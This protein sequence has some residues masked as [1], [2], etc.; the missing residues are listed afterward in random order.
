MD[1]KEMLEKLKALQ[2][3]LE[4]L[5]RYGDCY[6]N[7]CAEI[8]AEKVS[9]IH[10][11]LGSLPGIPSV[12][13]AM[14]VFPEGEAE[15]NTALAETAK[16]KS[17]ST[18]A[19]AAT[20]GLAILMFCVPKPLP[21]FLTG[22]AGVVWYFVY[23]THKLNKQ[24]LA[25]KEKAYQESLERHRASMEQFHLA[26]AAYPKEVKEGIE[27]A[28]SFGQRYREKQSE[29][30]T[31]LEDYEALKEAA[32]NRCTELITQIKGHDYIPEEYFHHVPKLITLL[33][34]GRADS[35]KEALN[36]AID[37]ERQDAIEAARKEEEARR[38]DALERQAE[39]ERRH[40]MMME[41]QEAAHQRA[42]ERQAQEQTELQ[43]RAA[44]QAERDKRK[45]DQEAF[46]QKAEAE[47]AARKQANATKMAGVSKCASCANSKRCPSHVKNSGA[48][49]TCGGYTPR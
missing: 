16:S 38:L 29:I 34:S 49:L 10:T 25:K 17:Y 44:V 2:A 12:V 24:G 23:K 37:E 31:A 41:R 4:D 6:E 39:E 3:L 8:T 26:L 33:Q 42:L 5:Q 19:L 40:N 7:G 47:S 9:R 36:I 46:R 35:Y 45:A 14:P 48:G 27:A 28:K 1:K 30:Y 43:R 32:L 11:D 22:V 21:V 15:Y 20:A 18:L 13:N